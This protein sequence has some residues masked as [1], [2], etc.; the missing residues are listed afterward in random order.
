MVYYIQIYW[1][2]VLRLSSSAL[3]TSKHNI[4]EAG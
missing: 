4:L 2:F 3:K 1:I